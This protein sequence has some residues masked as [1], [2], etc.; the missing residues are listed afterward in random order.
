MLPRRWWGF[1]VT[2]VDKLRFSRH[3]VKVNKH[4]LTHEHTHARRLGE[5]KGWLSLEDNKL[6]DRFRNLLIQ[7]LPSINIWLRGLPHWSDALPE[8]A[9]VSADADERACYQ[10]FC[11]APKYKTPPF[12]QA[13]R[14]FAAFRIQKLLEVEQTENCVTADKENGEFRHN[15]LWLVWK[16]DIK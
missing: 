2:F 5:F 10:P 3:H 6:A 11:S 16:I 14:Q 9:F 13:G 4:T 8:D 7:W 1:D 12:T 15:V